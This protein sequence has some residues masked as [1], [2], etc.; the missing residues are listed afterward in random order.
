MG[1][2]TRFIMR[3]QGGCRK[4][5][6]K[7]GVCVILLS[8]VAILQFRTASA[9][10]FRKEEAVHIDP[11]TI[12]NATLAIGT[13]LIYLHSLNEE[14]YAIALESASNSGQDKWYY[15]SELAG[16]MWL[17]I[18]DAGS[19]KE[20][21]AAG[22]IVEDS[23][24]KALYFTHHTKS[25]GITYDLRNNAQVCIFDIRNV[26][27]LELM[28]ELEALKLQYDA[29]LESKSSTKTAK[30]NQ[31]LVENFWEMQV[32]S[33]MTDQCD[34]QIQALQ[35]YYNE[36][37]ANGADSRETQT[38]LNVM[39][40]IDSARRAAVLSMVDSG[41]TSLQDAVANVEDESG[42]LELDDNL[43]TA[44]GDSQY[45][46]A[47]SLTEAQGNMLV[48]GNTVISEAEYKFS[49]EMISTA[50]GNNYFQ[51]DTQNQKLQLLDN[52]NSSRIVQR[53]EELNLLDILI[54]A[55]DKKYSEQLASGVT[56][57]YAALSAKNVSHAALQSKMREDI[58]EADAARG[59][60]QFLL[61]AK[62]DRQENDAA[63]NYVRSRIQDAAAFK[64]V[65]QAD[66]YRQEYQNSVTVYL[67][68]LNSLL[69]NIKD[70]DGNQSKEELFYEQKAALQEQKLQALDSLDLDT[71]KRIDA[72][73]AEVDSQINT[74]QAALSEQLQGLMKE[75]A[76]LEKKLAENPQNLQNAALQA[77]L[78]KLEAEI[79]DC[80]SDLASDS[81]TAN[82]MACKNEI[83][84][85][86]AKGD[87]SETT[88]SLLENDVKLLTEMMQ[89]GSALAQQ[90]SKEV[91]QK[92]LAKS[93]LEGVKAYQD[94][95]NQIE[96]A[97]SESTI[98]TNLSGE[99]P[100]S[101]AEQVIA[102][103]L[104]I[105][106]LFDTEGNL[107]K[108]LMALCGLAAAQSESSKE[109]LS[110]N[111]LEKE[112]SSES[113]SS[114]KQPELSKEELS[115]EELSKDKL[116]KEQSSESSSST[117]Q[118]K[119]N[120]E[121]L[122]A[123]L[124][125]LE[126]F[127]QETN[128]EAIQA[129]VRGLATALNQSDSNLIFQAKQQGGNA[130]I[131]AETLAAYL[132]YRYVWNDTKKSAVLSKGRQFFRFTAYLDTVETD[133][134]ATKKMKSPA[135]FFGE[136]YLPDS[137]VQEQFDCYCSEIS[138]T[139]YAVLVNQDTMK[140]SQEI[141]LELQQKQSEE[142]GF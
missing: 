45:A 91:Y 136:L 43:L 47:E 20:I 25:D 90:A 103:I 55:A 57:Q 30:R 23:E 6:T 139:D 28:P 19:I 62:V 34:K 142:G 76:A 117:A 111:E 2:L 131:S 87:I 127:G 94:L 40:K 48:E 82:I 133:T 14:I 96:T 29:I 9:A 101:E 72:K 67:D 81:Q 15:K 106:A 32:Q 100:A 99:L 93:E 26:Y 63:Q 74:S 108:E 65:I 107:S 112:Q 52:I 60:L 84:R 11:N 66:D 109:E 51:C 79:A 92:L 13:H 128:T 71:A 46:V 4:K 115:K 31:K 85:L 58:A 37:V 134:G 126:N 98:N 121:D 138:G 132:G 124:I 10:L 123:A 130:Y 69:S 24:I 8:V 38:V 137:F 122:A 116:E 110:E 64:T 50:E 3:H 49:M 73:I 1:N 16:G 120:Q 61:Q 78:S 54:E 39:E 113:S 7:I 119:S 104:G 83:L 33:D 18:S 114:T 118:I 70:E 42:E 89:E 105:D 22:K 88:R 36:L 135:E 102:D 41:L 17:D 77:Q 125:A 21:T 75:K 129:L 80:Q 12:E 59:E 141:L 68:W 97:L 5:Y 44:V 27:E 86:I 35:G 56:Q 140:K 95:Q 53:Q